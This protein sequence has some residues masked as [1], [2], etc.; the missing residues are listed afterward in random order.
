MMLPPDLS[1]MQ[2]E[3][4][5][6]AR[7]YGLDF[8]EVIFHLLDF[9]G[10]NEV[11]AY[12]GF[13]TRYPHW[14]F[15]MEYERLSK[16]YTYG[17]QKIYEMVI[18][19]DPCHA[20]LLTANSR[21]DQ[22]I[23]MAHVYAHCDFFKN[24]VWFA[25][26]NRK[27]VDEMANHGVRI[28]RYMEQ[29]GVEEVESFIDACLSIENLIDPYA[30]FIRRTEDRRRRVLEKEEEVPLRARKFKSK[31]YMNDF[32]NP[33]EYIEAQLKKVQEAME[34]KR[35]AFPPEPV[36]DVL[37]FLIEH[38]PLE[39]W[40]RDVLSIIREESYY[41]TPQGQ[42][43]IMNE[44]WASYW[45]STILT[46][47]VLTDAELIDYADHHSGTLGT[48]PGVINPYKL[49][50]ELFRDIEERWDKGRFGKEYEECENI[51]EKKRWDK[52]L[53]LGRQKI[54]EVRKVYNDVT[55]IDA[56]LTEEFCEKHRLF[57]Y[58]FNPKT[59]MYE[60][61]DRDYRKI[62]EKLLFGLTNFGLPVIHVLDG[63]YRNRGELY[64]RHASEGVD[65]KVGW[66]RETLKNIQRIWRRP[67]HL[68][69][70]RSGLPF[71]IGFDGKEVVEERIKAEADAAEEP[72]LETP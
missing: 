67:V 38:A 22:K 12:G 2:A 31:Q 70:R 49:G 25:K 42:T 72:A 5:K 48:R 30:P 28:A 44:G 60:I 43:K 6:H 34:R 7:S 8:F 26:T 64:L 3:I 45:H 51:A 11:A 9:D 63:N 27:M 56:F 69:T 59:R 46:R 65:L 71:R 62:K 1:V 52:K 15:G 55:F 36:R 17:L 13:P 16:G 50:L 24:N 4:E 53:G 35:K 57:T 58:R 21:V 54:F 19:N 14:R 23:V 29:H 33:R 10:I 41:F 20:Y 18:N 47:R 32:V 37:A 40:E 68:E 61:A 39:D 66:A